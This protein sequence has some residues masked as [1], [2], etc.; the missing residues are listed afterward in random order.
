[1]LKKIVF[2]LAITAFI[3]LNAQTVNSK[4]YREQFEF[5]HDNDFFLFTDRYYSSGLF[6]T[7]R[8]QLTKGLFKENSEQLDF[9]ISQEVYTPSQTQSTNSALF[10]RPYVGFS[11]LRTSWSTAKKNELFRADILVGIAGLNSGAGGLQRAFHD[12]IGILDSPL[13]IDELADSFHVN[14]YFSYVKEWVISPN[15]FGVR[16]ALIPNLA[17]GSR[18]I[19]IAPE[20]VF[21]FGKRNEVANSIAHTRIG[22][23]TKELYFA[24][25]SGFRGVFYNGLIEGNLFGD[26]SPL[27]KNPR[28][29]VWFFG[30]DV[31]H[32]IKKGDYKFGI[33]FNTSETAEAEAHK[34]VT[35][36]YGLRF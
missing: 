14:L 12:A 27:T 31:N 33:R 30:I 6:L 25:R 1:M 23:E 35:L 10:D 24:L 17:L 21:Y 13:W 34:Y 5:L 22:T 19:Y 7:Y 4:D 29:G 16:F 3:P 8:K 28:N 11:G 32:R 26:N 18:D 20:T 15:P 2:F 36:A 9:T